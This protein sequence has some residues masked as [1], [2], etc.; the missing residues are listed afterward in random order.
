M[1]R[2]LGIDPGYG[3]CGL[4]VLERREGRDVV[5]ESLCIET[6]GD[7]PF[8]ERLRE[9][10]RAICSLL[11]HHHPDAIALEEVFFGKNQK[12]AIRVAEV[13][14]MIL[15]L[16]L[17]RKL[18]VFEYNPGRVKIAVTGVGR[19]DKAQVTKMIPL[20]VKIE[21]QNVLDD[22]YDAIALALTHLAEDGQRWPRLTEGDCTQQRIA[23]Q[24]DL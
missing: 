19:A 4:A 3:R 1:V 20:L 2:V 7:R 16:A 24:K 8:P 10:A 23:R 21:K 18:P 9:V 6:E 5:L 12:T 22:E 17:E 11:E 15:Y 14:G 13:R